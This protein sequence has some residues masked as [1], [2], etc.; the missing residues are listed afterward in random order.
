LVFPYFTIT[1]I[2][3]GIIGAILG[4][5][6]EAYEAT[7][8]QWNPL[9][10]PARIFDAFSKKNELTDRESIGVF[11]KSIGLSES[12]ASQ[13]TRVKLEGGVMFMSEE[14]S[15]TSWL[16]LYGENTGVVGDKIVGR[17]DAGDVSRGLGGSIDKTRN[18]LAFGFI[19]LGY[20]V[21]VIGLAI[22]A[23]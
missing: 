3:L 23:T 11:L 18:R 14:R 21:Q 12:Q 7:L 17:I 1:N 19:F 8:G 2:G 6:P 20:V 13:V 10:K 5:F 9:L 4:T 16:T 15:S 22:G